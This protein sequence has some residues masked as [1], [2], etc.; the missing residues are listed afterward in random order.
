MTR[1]KWFAIVFV[2]SALFVSY[3]VVQRIPHDLALHINDKWHVRLI[4]E[5]Q[6]DQVRFDSQQFKLIKQDQANLWL[7]GKGELHWQEHVIT[8]SDLD[9]KFNHTEIATS[10]KRLSVNLFF[11]PD[12][13][14]L[15]GKA[16]LK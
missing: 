10:A 15:K 7:N 2:I 13:R 4:G 14:V 5:T 3:I 12:G 8:V 9:I 16:S 1:S 11:Y 6:P